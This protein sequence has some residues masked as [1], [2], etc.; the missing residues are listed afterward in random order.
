MK[1]SK[2]TPK[3][4]RVKQRSPQALSVAIHNDKD[5][6]VETQ[7]LQHCSCIMKIPR[8]RMKGN[9]PMKMTVL[10][11][12]QKS[13]VQCFF[14][15]L[16]WKNNYF[17]KLKFWNAIR[18]FEIFMFKSTKKKPEGRR[19]NIFPSS[20]WSNKKTL[21]IHLIS[22]IQPGDNT[23]L[24]RWKTHNHLQFWFSDFLNH[25]ILESFPN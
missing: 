1:L 18:E 11:T 15:T 14:S 10:R 4:L 6:P 5:C 23:I 17:S 8:W 2:R 16:T 3:H 22:C 9:F 24:L 13:G 25:K 21:I 20:F 19:K 12:V 7:V